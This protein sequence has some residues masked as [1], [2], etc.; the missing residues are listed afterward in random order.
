[1]KKPTTTLIIILCIPLL[2]AQEEVLLSYVEQGLESNL[3]L[4]QQQANYEKN[5]YALRAAKGL[6]FPDIDIGARYTVS[7]GGR[8]IDFPVG[9]LLNPV[10]STLNALTGSTGDDAFPMVENQR[11]PFYRPREHETKVSLVQPVLEPSIVYNY[12]IAKDKLAVSAIDIDIYRRELIHEIKTAYYNVLKAEYMHRLVDETEVLLKENLRVSIS[13]FRNDKVTE[14]VVYRSEAELQKVYL[15][16]AEAEKSL[17]SARAYLNFLL[18]RDLETPVEI[19][20]YDSVPGLTIAIREDSAVARGLA[21]REEILQLETYAAINENYTRIVKSENIPQLLLAV[22]Y[23]F[24]GEEYSFGADDDFLLASVVLRWNIF[25]GGTN[26]A[27]IQEAKI[28]E[29]QIALHQEELHSQ[30]QLQIISAYYELR[31]AKEAL[32]AARLQ[33]VAARKAFSVIEEKYR[34]GQAQLI[35]YTDAR[36]TMTRSR[37]ELILAGFEFKIRESALERA[38]ASAPLAK[39]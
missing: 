27:K 36:T 11:F 34:S 18:N 39:M 29:Q 19:I 3:A 23:G 10:Y 24:Q 17:N 20:E 28:S 7:Q 30:I 38:M 2:Y 25:Q 8:I 35:E 16:R 4:R 22:D 37:Q 5:L 21:S 15:A 13:L 31:A 1:M 26:R 12:R 6:F 32:D 33:S 9:D 14:D